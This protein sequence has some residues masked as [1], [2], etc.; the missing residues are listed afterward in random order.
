MW[1]IFITIYFI[2]AII[3]LLLGRF[4]TRKLDLSIPPI[5]TLIP[6]FN[7]GTIIM[8]IVF[9]TFHAIDHFDAVKLVE[10]FNKWYYS[11]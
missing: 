1:P 4:V 8:E 9:I 3:A 5:F 2:S 7:I 11:K 6:I 10:N